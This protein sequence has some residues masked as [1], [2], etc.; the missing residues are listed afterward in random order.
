MEKEEENKEDRENVIG[1]QTRNCT[2]HNYSILFPHSF[3]Y[4]SV[5]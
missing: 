1:D 2:F 4:D 5:P 3:Q